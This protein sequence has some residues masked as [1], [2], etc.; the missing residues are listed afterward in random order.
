MCAG[1]DTTKKKGKEEGEGKKEEKGEK[2]GRAIG[3]S[4]SEGDADIAWG[5][6]KAE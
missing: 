3:F 6:E 5:E 4:A 2:R 1:L